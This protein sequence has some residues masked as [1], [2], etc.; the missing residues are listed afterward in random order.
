MDW[1]CLKNCKRKE[2]ASKLLGNA[3]GRSLISGNNSFPLR[4]DLNA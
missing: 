1:K 2:S 3:M 4:S